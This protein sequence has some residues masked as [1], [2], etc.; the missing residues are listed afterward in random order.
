MIQQIREDGI[1]VVTLS[2]S[3]TTL[4]ASSGVVL[5][6]HAAEEATKNEV[7]NMLS[8][9][10]LPFDE[11]LVFTRCKV[12][13]ELLPALTSIVEA[14]FERLNFTNLMI[15]LNCLRAS[16]DVAR[17]FNRAKRYRVSLSEMG[18]MKHLKLSKLTNLLRQETAAIQLS[19][20]ILFRMAS[21]TYEMERCGGVD[22][23]VVKHS[24]EIESRLRR[25]CE[26]LVSRYLECD[27]STRVFLENQGQS[28]APAPGV[29]KRIEE[30][31][32]MIA[33][34]VHVVQLIQALRTLPVELFERYIPWSFTLLIKLIRCQNLDLRQVVMDVMKSRVKMLVLKGCAGSTM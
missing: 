26:E 32:M 34:D 6:S 10:R 11:L 22:E 13:L 23:S 21:M 19:R 2:A 16:L 7:V 3:N 5:A 27:D 28:E 30:G 8:R 33:F 12:Q 24:T 29:M 1:A 4:Y 17:D 15:L 25:H 20:T 18:F 9:G 31:R 14:H